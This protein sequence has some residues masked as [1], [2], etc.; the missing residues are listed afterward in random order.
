MHIVLQN[1]SLSYRAL[2]LTLLVSTL[3][4]LRLLVF[5]PESLASRIAIM[6][7]HGPISPA[8]V[9]YLDQALPEAQEKLADALLIQLDT[10]GGL[11]DSARAMV[12]AILNAPMPV[13]VWV[14]PD[15]AHAASA[16]V[17]IV[18][19]SSVAAMAPQ[20][21]LGAASPVSMSGVDAPS[22][23]EKKVVSDLC[24]LLRTM[25][26]SRK[27]NI[28]WYEKSVTESASLTATEAVMERVVDVVARSRDDLFEQ[29]QQRGLPWRG[30][31]VRLGEGKVVP[32]PIEPGMR[33]AFLSWLLHPQIAYF[34][35]LGG[36]VGLFFELSTPGAI[37]PGVIGGLCLLLGLYALS[38]LPFNVA[39]LLLILFGLVLFL[40]EIKIT[41]YGLLSV[42]AVISLF[43]GS[44]ILFKEGHGALTLGAP[45]IL[46]TVTGMSV[47]L[48]AAVWLT[49]KAQLGAPKVGAETMLGQDATVVEWSGKTGN[50]RIHGELWS[51]VSDSEA[52]YAAGDVVVVESRQGLTLRVA[53]RATPNT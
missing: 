24:G 20:T 27:R 43:M 11:V 40:L 28:A 7:L 6:E 25:A 12:K 19:A 23:M 1:V 2:S 16:G 51:A 9:D 15:G 5:C 53:S 35:L 18:A 45:I 39:G 31:T 42:A 8:S 38:V 13:V 4:L 14:G 49:G 26:Q 47:L 21:T 33:H 34:L 10:P 52:A 50:V 41:S 37:L 17:F 22:T 3:F 30:G 36:L 29:L 44:T 48:G 32:I 46:V